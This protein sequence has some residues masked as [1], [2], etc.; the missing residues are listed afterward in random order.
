M[1]S[2]RHIIFSSHRLLNKLM[3]GKEGNTTNRKTFL[4]AVV[5][6]R[7]ITQTVCTMRFTFFIIKIIEE[8]TSAEEK[9]KELKNGNSFAD[10]K[11]VQILI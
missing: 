3:I 4:K 9:I 10:L 5:V 6:T 2:K 1:Q 8:L 7:V 11:L